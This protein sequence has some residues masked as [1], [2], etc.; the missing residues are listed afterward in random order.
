MEEINPR[1]YYGPIEL[2]KYLKVQPRTIQREVERGNLPAIRIGRQ[3]RFTG[4][5]ILEYIAKNQI[6][7]KRDC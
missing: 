4:K 5:S 7:P 1:E 3:I 6:K 2:A